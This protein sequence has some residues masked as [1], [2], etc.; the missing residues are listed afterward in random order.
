MAKTIIIIIQTN[1]P[2][3]GQQRR[4][5]G[6]NINQVPLLWEKMPFIKEK[7]YENGSRIIIRGYCIPNPTKD[8]PK[9]C[10]HKYGR[11]KCGEKCN[12]KS[13]ASPNQQFIYNCIILFFRSSS[14]NKRKRV[15]NSFSF[16]FYSVLRLDRVV[17]PKHG[18][19]NLSLARSFR[20]TACQKKAQNGSETAEKNGASTD[21]LRNLKQ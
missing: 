2:D 14:Y 13:R 10:S 9:D 11:G 19:L 1:R 15:S 5:L 12:I 7:Q 18:P 16:I 20:I 8:V 3:L 6:Y 4:L 21:S 17:T